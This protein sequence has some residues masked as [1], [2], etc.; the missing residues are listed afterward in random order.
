MI[1]ST[2]NYVVVESLKNGYNT[3]INEGV[4]TMYP[5][6]LEVTVKPIIHIF[7]STTKEYKNYHTKDIVD[8]LSYLE[9]LSNSGT[10]FYAISHEKEEIPTPDINEYTITQNELDEEY[11][12]VF[13][14]NI[15]AYNFI[16]L[17]IVKDLE[18][19]KAKRNAIDYQND[20][21]YISFTASVPLDDTEYPIQ[22]KDF[23]Q[24]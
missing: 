2:H 10:L 15:D 9:E 13:K 12:T 24:V 20:F 11:F 8:V 7:N 21:E 16:Q 5:H 4:P 14:E 1:S 19:F 22:L 6:H 18:Q 17:Y 3:I 23:L